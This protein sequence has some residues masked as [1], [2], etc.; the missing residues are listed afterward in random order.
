MTVLG[1]AVLLV[2]SLVVYRFFDLKNPSTSYTQKSSFQQSRVNTA[3]L[4]QAFEYYLNYAEPFALNQ[5]SNRQSNNDLAK[6]TKVIKKK[7]IPKKIIWPKISYI[8]TM[9]GANDGEGHS[10]FIELDEKTITLTNQDSIGELKILLL[11]QDSVWFEKEK[12][13][14]AFYLEN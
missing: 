5:K 2:W 6:K 14:K 8:G 12:E 1:M 11:S 10:Y 4:T 3:K 13:K 7:N 9:N